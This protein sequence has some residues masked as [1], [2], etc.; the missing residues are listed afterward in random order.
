MQVIK[1]YQ[2]EN[3]AHW[4]EEIGKGDW[5]AAELLHDWLESDKLKQICG[6]STEVYL[7]TDGDKLVSFATLAPQDEIDA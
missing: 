7:L 4:R 6:D 2:S 1:Y 3:Q 5:S